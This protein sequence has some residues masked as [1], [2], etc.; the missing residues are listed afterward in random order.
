MSEA[1]E[2][3]RSIV[4]RVVKDKLSRCSEDGEISVSKDA[5]LAFSESGRIFIHY[6]SATANDIC[7]ESKRQIINVEDVFKALEE[8]E[9]PEFL[10][11]LKASLEEFRKKNAGKKAAV[12]KGKD[13]EPRKKR[14]LE[15]ESPDKGEG[16]DKAELSDKG[17][18]PDK[19]E[20]DKGES[21]DETNDLKE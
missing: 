12:S 18:D 16:S 8:T 13:D 9:F 2:L 1:E 10:R 4:R 7:K 19:G 3:P 21:G 14:K 20:S 15:G 5:L 6:L 11:P 17:E